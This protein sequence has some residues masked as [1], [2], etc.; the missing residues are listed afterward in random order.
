MILVA[1]GCSHTAGAELEYPFQRSCYEK[2]WPK[3]LA[4]LLDYDHL[5][6]S[7]SG[8]SSHRVVRTTMRYV[9]D[10]FSL[11]NDLSDHLFI[12]NWPG[13][14]RTELRVLDD[15]SEKEKLLF[16]DDNWLPLIIGNDESYKRNFTKRLYAFYKSWVLTTDVIK[17]RLDYV[18]DILMLQNFFMLYKIKFLF[19]S[20]SYVNITQEHEELRGYKSLISK[21]T[22]PYF[23]NID[24]SYNVLLKNNKQCISEFSNQS[25]FAAHYDEES[26]L[27][28]AKYLHSYIANSSII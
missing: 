5:N 13:A 27:W 22:F 2:A 11:K 21:K 9:I 1:N 17:P 24:F 14:N 16:Y 19:W 8:A 6:L 26:Q 23:D 25:G 4:N 28:F 7:D 15:G 12:I 3:H 18:H 20:A 10:N